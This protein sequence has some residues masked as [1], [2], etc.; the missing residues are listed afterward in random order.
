MT[1]P[2]Q[3]LVVFT[4]ACQDPEV[5]ETILPEIK[6]VG[7]RGSLRCV[8]MNQLDNPVY[9]VLQKMI[10]VSHKIVISPLKSNILKKFNHQ[11]NRTSGAVP[12]VVDIFKKY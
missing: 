3:I 4:G 7:L 12:L 1:H 2:L 8:V 5:A 10:R 9:D 11:W 6:R